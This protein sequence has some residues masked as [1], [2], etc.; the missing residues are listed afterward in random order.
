MPLELDMILIRRVQNYM[1]EVKV[2]SGCDSN[3]IQKKKDLF[4]LP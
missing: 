2:F 1:S 3:E 4:M